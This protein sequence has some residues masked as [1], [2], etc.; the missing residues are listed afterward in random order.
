MVHNLI[1]NNIDKKN[2]ALERWNRSL[3]KNIISQSPSLHEIG[4]ELKKQH[5]VSETKI[6]RLLFENTTKTLD[7]SKEKLRKAVINND[8]LYDLFYL[9]VIAGVLNIKEP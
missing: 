3:N 2:N 4:Y 8:D 6:S 7:S 5:A 1:I 9:K